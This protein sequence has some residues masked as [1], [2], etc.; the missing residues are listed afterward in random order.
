MKTLSLY[1]RKAIVR[2]L[3]EN[4]LARKKMLKQ[5]ISPQTNR[6]ILQVLTKKA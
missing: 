1:S 6:R 2:E 3:Y 5:R 4:Y